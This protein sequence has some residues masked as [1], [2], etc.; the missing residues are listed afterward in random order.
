[1]RRFG[2]GL[3]AAA[4]ACAASVALLQC[5]TSDRV[6]PKGATITLA[7]TPTTIPLATSNV[8]TTI[9]QQATCGEAQVLATVNSEL[10]SPL[11]DQDVRFSSTAGRLFTGSDTSPVD[12]SNVPIRTDSFGNAEVNLITSTTA[13]VTAH[14][15]QATPGTLTINTVQ[16]NLSLITLNLD[17]T[18]TCPT[19]TATVITCSQPTCLVAHAVDTSNN[20]VTGLVIL[21]KI[22]SPT[23]TNTFTGDFSPAQPTT[24]G[25]GDAKTVLT[26][27]STCATP[28]SPNQCNQNKCTGA[29]VIASTQGGLQSAPLH[30]TISIP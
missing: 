16:G 24:D 4:A 14:S 29:D 3:V 21:F 20:P 26:P 9:L 7:A 12:A 15:G 2:T 30:L 1:M 19:P 5:K 18:T 23:G 28:M 22:V 27:G 25:N 6:P 17:T 13:T 10:G 11:P 8:C